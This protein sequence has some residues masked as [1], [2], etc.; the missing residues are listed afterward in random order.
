MEKSLIENAL[1]RSKI[2]WRRPPNYS[3]ENRLPWTQFLSYRD[4]SIIFEKE[5]QYPFQNCMTHLCSSKIDQMPA[6]FLRCTS[7]SS[8]GIRG[9][10]STPQKVGWHLVNFWATGM[11]HTVLERRL[12]F[13]FKNDCQ[14]SL[15]QKLSSRE[16]IFWGAHLKRKGTKTLRGTVNPVWRGT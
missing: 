9:L 3:S 16:P 12:N 2:L 1:K 8:D 14:I 7:D 5:I 15:A 4:V 11:C 13:L 10:L 6:D